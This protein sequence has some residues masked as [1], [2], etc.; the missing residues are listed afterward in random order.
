MQYE[1]AA[2]RDQL[3]QEF[4]PDDMC[5]LGGQMFNDKLEH[6]H[7]HNVKNAPAFGMDEDP[8]HDHESNAPPNSKLTIELPN[9]LS[10]D[11]LLQSVSLRLNVAESFIKPCI[12]GCVFTEPC[13][14]FA[15]RS[16]RQR[17]MSEEC[18]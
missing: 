1:E 9:L 14:S 17:T 12:S 4:I 15:C 8:H 6:G 13:I 5:S 3:L 10:V 16:W 7:E 2:I 18:R 11:Q